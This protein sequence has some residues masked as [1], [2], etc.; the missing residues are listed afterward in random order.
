MTLRTGNAKPRLNYLDGKIVP[1]DVALARGWLP[2]VT[3]DSVAEE[4]QNYTVQDVREYGEDNMD[5][6]YLGC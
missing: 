2:F 1:R 4:T 3:C 6:S 5:E